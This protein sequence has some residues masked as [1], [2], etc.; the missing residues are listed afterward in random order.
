ML[1]S[2]KSPFDAYIGSPGNTINHLSHGNSPRYTK[3]TGP[4]R[5]NHHPAERNKARWP[6]LSKAVDVHSTQRPHT[7]TEK[8]RPR[9]RATDL[10]QTAV[11]FAQ[12]RPFSVIFSEVDCGLGQKTGDNTAPTTKPGHAPA[13]PGHCLVRSRK[14]RRLPPSQGERFR[15]AHPPAHLRHGRAHSASAGSSR[16]PGSYQSSGRD[17]LRSPP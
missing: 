10:A 11:H 2:Y 1:A 5:A 4:G 15:S 17:A 9:T 16:T 8:G 7:G 12:I 14:S 6:I 3:P 13:R